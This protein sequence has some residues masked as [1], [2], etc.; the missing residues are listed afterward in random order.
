MHLSEEAAKTLKSWIT[1]GEF[2][3]TEPVAML[4]SDRTFLPQ[5]IRGF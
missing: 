5:D 1:K 4:P 3:L 2:T